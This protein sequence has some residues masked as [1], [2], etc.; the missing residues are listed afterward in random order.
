MSLILSPG[1]KL[2]DFFSGKST[3]TFRVSHSFWG[4]WV[5]NHSAYISFSLSICLSLGIFTY[6]IF[7]ILRMFF[8]AKVIDVKW[9]FWSADLEFIKY[10]PS[11]TRHSCLHL[12]AQMYVPTKP[13]T[14]PHTLIL[15]QSRSEVHTCSLSGFLFR[16]LSLFI[17]FHAW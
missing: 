4:F 8:F 15:S 2:S 7:W 16:K 5:D 11:D 10:M 14:Y 13:Y 3:Y 17:F 6:F 9:Y 12:P 1:Q